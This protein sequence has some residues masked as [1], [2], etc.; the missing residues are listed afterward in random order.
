MCP[1]PLICFDFSTRVLNGATLLPPIHYQSQFSLNV[2]QSESFSHKHFGGRRFGAYLL[3]C[4]VIVV[5]ISLL[6]RLGNSPSKNQF[7]RKSVNVAC[8]NIDSC[9]ILL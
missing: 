8:V 5:L 3:L 1:V 6:V 9:F 7:L 2:I 4:F